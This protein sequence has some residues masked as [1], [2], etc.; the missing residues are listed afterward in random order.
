MHV[1]FS[2]YD[3]FAV[4]ALLDVVGACLLAKGLFATPL[5]AYRRAQPHC[6]Y[7]A[8]QIV[9]MAADSVDGHFGAA[10]LVL[11]F[12]VQAAAYLLTASGIHAGT[13]G[14]VVAS[15]L[16]LMVVSGSLLWLPWR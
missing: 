8:P 15:S 3:A 13:G 4:G 7:S 6:D 14:R 5:E 9:G 2:L 16:A 11:G 1:V 12:A 10:A